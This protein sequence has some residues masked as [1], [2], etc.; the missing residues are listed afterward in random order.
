MPGRENCEGLFVPCALPSHRRRRGGKSLLFAWESAWLHFLFAFCLSKEGLRGKEER[1]REEE[2]LLNTHHM[3]HTCLA[4]HTSP[5]LPACMPWGR[6]GRRKLQGRQADHAEE[7]EAFSCTHSHHTA[8][9]GKKKIPNN[10]VLCNYTLFFIHLYMLLYIPHYTHKLPACH[11]P[12]G[13]FTITMNETTNP[14]I[15]F[16]HSLHSREG[17]DGGMGWEAVALHGLCWGR[18][19][20]TP[21]TGK[22][23]DGGRQRWRTCCLGLWA[24]AI[25]HFTPA[26][27]CLH[28]WTD[29]TF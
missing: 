12:V 5:P 10:Y 24:W 28:T 18:Q 23:W 6:R 7:G 29:P 3:P 8:S 25:S 16:R 26:L 15:C 21:T 17:Q 9:H 4:M 2:N 11:T 19:G 22:A 14:G 27:T 20:F 1:N 13:L